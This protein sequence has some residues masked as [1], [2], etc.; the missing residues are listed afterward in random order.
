MK[1]I[2]IT[3][4]N[5]SGS[6]F[7]ANIFSKYSEILVCPE[8][9]IL[10]YRLL[11]NPNKQFIYDNKQKQQIKSF[12]SNDKK[13]KYW[14]LQINDLLGLNTVKTNFDAFAEILFAYQRKVKPNATTIVFKGTKLI[15]LYEKISREIKNKYNLKYISIIRD[16]RAVFA[17]QK[18]TI[19]PSAKK[20]FATNPIRVA[21]HWNGFVNNSLKYKNDRDYFIV[22]YESLIEEYEN[23][24]KKL[25]EHLELNT[26]KA[27]SKHGD[28][29]ERIP[30][31]QKPIHLYIIEDPQKEKIDSWKKKLNPIHIYIFEK[32]SGVNLLKLGYE[33]INPEVNLRK[34]FFI[35]LYFKIKLIYKKIAKIFSP[36][37]FL[38]LFNKIV[39]LDFV[40]KKKLLFLK[41][42]DFKHKLNKDK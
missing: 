38:F 39:K 40:C 9:D 34:L 13:L 30:D 23:S 3:Y 17:S 31:Y 21:T 16:G 37:R 5:R 29:F 33:I 2:F 26:D 4:V 19:S 28:L 18:R 25:F 36:T 41:I 22:K 27:Y 35:E 1:I 11:I 20:K 14:G 10:I 8:A 6:T 12:I 42:T 24:I 7:L 15:D 32:I